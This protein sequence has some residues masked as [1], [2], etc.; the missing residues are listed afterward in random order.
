MEMANSEEKKYA[1]R[2]G[3]KEVMN[4]E[5]YD[6]HSILAEPGWHDAE[7][8]WSSSTALRYVKLAFSDTMWP[9]Q[10]Y[11]KNIETK[12]ASWCD[13]VDI[14]VKWRFLTILRAISNSDRYAQNIIPVSIVSLMYVEHVLRVPVDW[15]TLP[16]T[17]F[18]CLSEMYQTRKPTQIPYVVVPIWF[19]SDP[20]LLDDPESPIPA[21][22]KPWSRSRPRK[23][24]RLSVDNELDRDLGAAFAQMEMIGA[25]TR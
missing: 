6:D 3:K 14:E 1:H 13:L 20:A 10:C 18:G 19:R 16:S 21:N 4:M 12:S 24:R 2:R 8:P 9:R 17:G 15:S 22:R 5:L 11:T 25:V 23:R 7:Q